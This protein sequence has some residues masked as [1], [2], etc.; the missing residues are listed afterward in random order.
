MRLL[1]VAVFLVSQ[2]SPSHAQDVS[3][4]AVGELGEEFNSI[5]K[6]KT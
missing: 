2:F 1:I 6:E 3:D 5:C 4:D